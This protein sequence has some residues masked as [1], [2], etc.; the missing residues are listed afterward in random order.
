M[1]Y[2]F[3]YGTLYIDFEYD[4]MKNHD[5]LFSLVKSGLSVNGSED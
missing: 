2:F 4:Q 1:S 3:V 5:D